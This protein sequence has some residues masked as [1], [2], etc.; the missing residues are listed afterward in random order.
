MQND[1]NKYR[2]FPLLGQLRSYSASHFKGDLNAGITVGIILIPQAMAYS[3][4][5]GLPPVYG[6]YASI[7]PLIIYAFL[8]SSRHLGMGPVAII[9]LL[10]IAG[11]GELA[12]I[13]SGRF[14]Q[15]T[16]LTAFGV[17]IFQLL[18]GIMRMGFIANFLSKPVLS[19]FTSAAA[20][21]I[22][23]SQL[24]NLFGVE[25]PGTTQVHE[26]AVAMIQ[27]IGQIDP[28]TTIIG[29]GSLITIVAVNKWKETFP[30]ALIVVI[31]GTFITYLF[32]LDGMGVAIVGDIPR[33]LPSFGLT[34]IN[35]ADLQIL[36]PTILVIALVSYVESIA[37][38]KAIASKHGY[39]IDPNQE[40]VALGFAKFGG[41]FFQSFPTA[42]SFSRTALNDQAGGRTGIATIIS[43]GIIALTLI[44][45]TPLFFYMPNAV[46][47]AIIIIAVARLFDIREMIEL[48][49]ID[50]KDLAMLLITFFSTLALG[51]EEGIAVGVVISLTV[52]IYSSTKPHSAELGRL[53]STNSYRNINRYPEAITNDEI[54]IFR[55]DSPLY[56]ASAEHFRDTMEELIEIKNDKLKL[57]I[58][59][60]SA[61]NEIDSTGI[62]GMKELIKDLKLRRITFYISGAIGPVRDKLKASG[63][64]EI[65]GEENFFFDVTD[66]LTFFEGSEINNRDDSYSPI[67]T[68]I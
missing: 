46:L 33:G 49:T 67:Q 21:I 20:L 68:N 47:A 43:A 59:D 40:L 7:V 63:I 65:M 36:F 23:A 13:G 18:M 45:L 12:E 26:V 41:A 15:L 55:F 2:Y 1:S 52:L 19:G 31:L 28:V 54:L 9:S 64:I 44:F 17:G 4:L 14:L 16:I 3:V 50:I 24:R 53:G 29:L 51:I 32:R 39:K 10:I 11:I 27:S 58:L 60:A 35:M 25:L 37:V 5:A 48:W 38:A 30:A 57:I 8:G 62:H 42:G 66:A 6:L 61:I 22:I 56:F 34:G